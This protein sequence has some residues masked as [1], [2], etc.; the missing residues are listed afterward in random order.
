MQ[1]MILYVFFFFTSHPIKIFTFC[2]PSHCIVKSSVVQEW[3]LTELLQITWSLFLSLIS[4]D[5]RNDKEEK[6]IPL[7]KIDPGSV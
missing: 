1:Y 7:Q 3:Y 4:K 2:F 6:K 5:A